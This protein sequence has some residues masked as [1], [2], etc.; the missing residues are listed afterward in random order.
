[1]RGSKCFGS[2]PF[3]SRPSAQGGVY[4]E[5]DGGAS[6]ARHI[7]YDVAAT[8]VQTVP[9]GSGLLGQTVTTTNTRYG[10]GF[11]ADQKTGFDVDAIVGYGFGLFRIEGELGY[12]RSR[13]RKVTASDLLLGD[14]NT[15]P[16]SGVSSAGLAPG[17]HT[18]VLSGMGNALLNYHLTPG[19]R[20]YGGG[21]AGRA[22]V[23][24]LG[25]RD[26]AW[27]FQGIAG[28][29]VPIAANLE[30]G[31]KYRYFQTGSLDFRGGASFANAATG[32]TSVSQFAEHGKFR[33]NSLLVSLTY[34]LD[35]NRAP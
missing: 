20:I 32:A 25:D 16:I 2:N 30:L 3:G 11:V 13:L 35:G 27:A 18:S 10:N 9:T 23:W 31:V 7:G 28:A 22:R 15:A 29:A 34:D 24:S 1:M 6:F 4:T 14:I 26:D 5:I 33:S 12:K 21:G 19:L 8:R 17:K